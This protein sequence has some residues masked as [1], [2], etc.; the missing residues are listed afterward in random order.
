MFVKG[1]PD[2]KKNTPREAVYWKYMFNC[3][4]SEFADKVMG[5]S[6][7]QSG[8]NIKSLYATLSWRF[9]SNRPEA[10]LVKGVL[11]TC[12][13]FTGEHPFRSAISIKLFCT[14]TWVFSCKCLHISRTPFPKNTS[15]LLLLK[16]WHIR[17]S[18]WCSCAFSIFICT[19]IQKQPLE[20]FS[21]KMCS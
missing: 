11:E 20:V 7:H 17:V 3:Y 5:Y 2:R 9:R 6:L 12:G 1:N 10:F 8:E 18:L 14:S 21:K 13:K 19:V 4:I 16:I 15:G